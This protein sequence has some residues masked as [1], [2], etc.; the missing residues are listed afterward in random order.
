MRRP[1]GKNGAKKLLHLF[2][3]STTSTRNGEYRLN[4]MRHRLSDKGAGKYE[5]SPT[6]SK[7]L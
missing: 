3:L 1:P 2:A 6:L 5:G 4:E 7:N